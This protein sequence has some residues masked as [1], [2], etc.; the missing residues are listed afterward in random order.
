MAS[1]IT[2]FIRRSCKLR[3]ELVPDGDSKN[4][5][6]LPPY[7]DAKSRYRKYVVTNSTDRLFTSRYIDYN[8]CLSPTSPVTLPK[9]INHLDAIL[10]EA[11]YY[12]F[13][14]PPIVFIND[15]N[16][17]NHV[18]D[19]SDAGILDVT[20]NGGYVYF[21]AKGEVLRINTIYHDTTLTSKLK[22]PS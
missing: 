16:V 1:P 15:I 20:I 17:K 5:T 8:G 18:K 9:E 7:C 6:N 4:S 3:I 12:S 22:V 14:C 19:K 2:C 13:I 10:D 11:T 21:I